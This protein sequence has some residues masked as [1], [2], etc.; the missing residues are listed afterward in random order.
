MPFVVDVSKVQLNVEGAYKNGKGNTECVVFVQQAPLVGGGSVPGTSLW[1]KG[2]YVKDA[3]AGEIAKGTVIATFDDN[4]NYPADQ[5]HAAVYISQ[6]DNG[7]TVY[8]QWNSQ[9]KVLQRV[10]RYTESTT[11]SVNNGNFF[12]VVET[13]ATVANAMTEPEHQKMFCGPYGPSE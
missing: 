7:I 1:K 4:G 3:K 10:L 11:R 9:K 8:D 12:W 5:R 2:K 13:A 6:D